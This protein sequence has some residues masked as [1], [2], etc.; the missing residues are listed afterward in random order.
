MTRGLLPTDWNYETQARKN[1]DTSEDRVAVGTTISADSVTITANH[2]VTTQAAQIAGTHDV[3]LA[4]GH[5]LIIG[6]GLSTHAEGHEQS[7]STSGFIQNGLSV[8]I[9]N[10]KQKSTLDVTQIDSTGSLIGSTDGRVTLAAGQDV[11]ITGSDV[12]SH[13]GTSIIGQNVTIDAGLGSVDTRQTQSVHSGGI[14]VGFAGGVADSVQG[15]YASAH[16]AGQ[17]DDD[18]LKALYAVQAGV[19]AYDAVS[20]IKSGAAVG[21]SAGDDGAEGTGKATG[22]SLRVGLGASTANSH[23]TTHDDTTAG[24][25]IRSDGDVTIVAKN[26][27]LNVIGSQIDGK[28]V[29]LAATGDLN[30]LSQLEA[31][32]QKSSS[33]NASGEIGFSVGSQT[34]IYVTA[35]VGKG[36]AHGNGTTN[37][38][39][40]VN[41]SDTL[42]I[43]SGN[44]T[45]ILGAQAKGETVVASIGGD[46]NIASHQ[47]TNDYASQYWQVGGTYVYGYGSQVNIAAGKTTSNYKSVDEVSGIGAGV[48]GYDVYVGGNTDLKGGVIASAADASKNVLSTGSLT[49]SDIENKAEYKSASGGISAGSGGFSGSMSIPQ[50][51]NSSSTTKAGIA[52][53]TIEVRN[54]P[55]VDLSGLDR[56]PNIDAGGLKEIFDEKKVADRQELGQAVGQLGMQAAGTLAGYMRDRAT[57]DDER[58]AWSDGG[59][60]RTALHGMVGAVT[61][62][63]GGGDVLQGALGAAASEQMAGVMSG[64]LT[65]HHIDPNS[66]AGKALMQMASIAVGGVAGAGAGAATALQGELYNHQLHEDRRESVA[67]KTGVKADDVKAEIV[68]GADAGGNAENFFPL[69]Y[70]ALARSGSCPGEVNACLGVATSFIESELAKGVPLDIF[71]SSPSNTD[72]TNLYAMAYAVSKDLGDHLDSPANA[73]TKELLQQKLA[74]VNSD[75]M[76]NIGDLVSTQN[77]AV[78]YGRGGSLTL[79]NADALGDAGFANAFNEWLNSPQRAGVENKCYI[80]VDGDRENVVNQAGTMVLGGVIQ[81]GGVVWTGVASRGG[82]ASGGGP[83]IG[84]PASP[85]LSSVNES[86]VPLSDLDSGSPSNVVLF[87]RLK[88]DLAAQELG[89][90]TP[91]GSALKDDPLHRAPSYVIDQIPE[92]ARFFS[93]RGGDQQVY[94]LTQ[95]EGEVNGK[96]GVFEWLTSPSGELTHQRFIPGGQISGSP[97][98]V[99]SRLTK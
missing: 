38:N 19:D 17:V 2:D 14:N 35:N 70:G 1:L 21:D 88:A 33:A 45:N 7:V 50:S 72:E 6:T 29:A 59:I 67:A 8:T 22:I 9:G 76:V 31:H 82:M 27:D 77:K 40:S 53:G 11:H 49:F 51:K 13:T 98:Q 20:G 37:A 97:N 91:V 83:S 89:S 3:T 95:M 25:S 90:F 81:I 44:D 66:D 10:Q 57:T 16:R 12:L 4:A 69:V 60:Y 39:T 47:A 28:N 56:T 36:I 26:G 62:K 84:E 65:E 58:A 41:A 43:V 63:L 96:A 64:Y 55:G 74:N 85:P 93:V 92:N 99:P 80:C 87:E 18:R 54:Q 94:N 75:G 30:L 73:A 48:G 71:I 24:S 23:S 32:T 15:A 61:A 52:E 5:D 46:L 34:G 78:A 79:E 42:S 86:R 68:T